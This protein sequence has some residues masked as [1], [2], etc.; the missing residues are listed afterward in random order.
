MLSGEL[1]ILNVL[2]THT[3]NLIRKKQPGM[4][5]YLIDLY[6]IKPSILNHQFKLNDFDELFIETTVLTHLENRYTDF[7]NA[8][9]LSNSLSYEQTIGVCDFIIQM[10]LRNPF[11]RNTL[12]RNKDLWL[13]D[14]M[15]NI[16]EQMSQNPI[17]SE[18]PENIRQHFLELIINQN[19]SDP[20]YT[21]KL[22][23]STIVKRYFNEE[24]RNE[25][26][27]EAIG[28]CQWS[29]IVAPK[30]G[31]Y[32]ITTDN[33]GFSISQGMLYNTRFKDGFAFF[34]PFSPCYCLIISDNM[35]DKYYSNKNGEKIVF[36]N[37]VDCEMIKSINHNSCRFVNKLLIAGDDSYLSKIKVTKLQ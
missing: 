17:Y 22:Q 29:I 24:N 6:K 9:T 28:N 15:K 34:F 19:K 25:K 21:E 3:K 23:Q 12:D 37:E 8:L 1:Y 30:D 35:K 20:T 31:P 14:T 32:F 7:Y 18:I 4:V 16:Q 10:K 26:F 27:R 5:C 11:Y 2:D 36:K 13:D 33:P